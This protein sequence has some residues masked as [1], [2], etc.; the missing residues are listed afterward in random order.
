MKAISLQKTLG[1]QFLE[2]LE[3]RPMSDIKII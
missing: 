2:G 3:S 1:K